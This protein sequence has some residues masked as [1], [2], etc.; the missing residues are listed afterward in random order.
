M[1][2]LISASMDAG[3]PARIAAV[4]SD[5]ADAKGLD[6][7]RQFSIPA[8]AVPRKDFATRTAHEEA[9]LAAISGSG[10]RIVALAGYMRLLSADFI[11]VWRGRM[12]N[13]HPSLLPSFPGLDTHA[14][15]LAAGC[16]IHGCTVHFVTEGMDEGPIIAQAAVPVASEDSAE[17]LA[18]RVLQAEHRIYPK[19]LALLA[20][21]LVRMTGDGRTHFEDAGLSEGPEILMA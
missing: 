21:G 11:H 1:A 18:A 19:V 6:I 5:R 4:I 17:T 3:Y 15:A 10:A 7:A 14:R 16:R 9:V 12:I 2:A 20:A 8:I 13:I